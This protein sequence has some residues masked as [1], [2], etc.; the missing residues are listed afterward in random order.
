ML[1]TSSLLQLRSSSEFPTL[2]LPYIPRFSLCSLHLLT[3]PSPT[4]SSFH[5]VLLP[6]H[7]FRHFPILLSLHPTLFLFPTHLISCLFHSHFSSH[8]IVSP[9]RLPILYP[10]PLFRF[11][12][13]LLLRLVFPTALGPSLHP[14][15]LCSLFL[16]LPYPAALL[17]AFTTHLFFLLATQ[18]RL[19][20]CL[21]LPLH[22]P[23]PSRANLRP[24]AAF[25]GLSITSR[26]YPLHVTF[27][28]N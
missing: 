18:P 10:I 5:Y 21:F 15:P 20:F 4:Y 6:T 28:E 17:R 1:P 27:T 9:F 16:F 23:V 25:R 19:C 3:V 13:L 14:T 11:C 24:S 7:S 2:H 26:L 12:N 22:T 8:F